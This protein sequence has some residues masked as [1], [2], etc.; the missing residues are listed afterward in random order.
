MS[1]APNGYGLYDVSG[2]VWEW[3]DDRESSTLSDYNDKN[4]ERILRGGSW[5]RNPQLENYSAF[6]DT[7]LDM[8]GSRYPY[9]SHS[10]VYPTGFRC[11]ADEPIYESPSKT[12]EPTK[13][14]FSPILSMESTQVSSIDG[15]TMVNI[16]SGYFNMGASTEEYNLIVE[17][18]TGL[19][20]SGRKRIEYLTKD[21]CEDFY[22]DEIPEHEIWIDSF[23]MD[24]SEVTSEQYHQFIE[25]TEYSDWDY[26]SDG[27]Y[28]AEYVSWYDAQAYCEWAG[29]R[30]PTEA[31][32]EKAA[33]GGLDG[34]M[35]PWG[36]DL[37]TCNEDDMNGALYKDCESGRID[38][39]SFSMNG[40]GLFDMVGSVSEWVGDW[41]TKDYYSYSP[42]HNPSG[43]ESGITKV[44]RGG[45]Y[46]DGVY[47]IRIASRSYREP[48]FSWL[49]VGFRCATS[50]P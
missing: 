35:Y 26:V 18:C 49:N 44:I 7:R 46:G 32:W 43:P 9:D 47:V 29:R 10:R 23:W 36:D 12:I 6:Y 45:G 39:K 20:Q 8:E 37:P 16:P 41:Y 19:V 31:E 30:L 13:D 34:K 28:P 14:T 50:D 24:Q 40:F 21:Q 3:V 11:A 2:N 25:D 22:I 1:F 33:R 42:E 38:V 17:A 27:N 4:E 48:D 15:M 5:Y